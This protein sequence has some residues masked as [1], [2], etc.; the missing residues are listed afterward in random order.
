MVGV[1][2]GGVCV[3]GRRRASVTG[4]ARALRVWFRRASSACPRRL[5]IVGLPRWLCSQRWWRGREMAFDCSIKIQNNVL[6]AP[7]LRTI[8]SGVGGRDGTAAGCRSGL[9][10]AEPRCGFPPPLS[11]RSVIQPGA[12]P[13]LSVSGYTSALKDTSKLDDASEDASTRRATRAPSGTAY[14]P[15]PRSSSGIGRCSS[16]RTRPWRMDSRRRR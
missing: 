11:P 4:L 5:N 15:P 12:D 10:P 14:W 16:C 1:P 13:E 8:Q 7:E 6:D 9:M 2:V 3:S